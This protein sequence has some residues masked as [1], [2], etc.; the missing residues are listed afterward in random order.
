M[1]TQIPL[2]LAFAA[3]TIHATPTSFAALNSVSGTIQQ[4]EGFHLVGRGFDLQ[5]RGFDIGDILGGSLKDSITSLLNTSITILNAILTSLEAGIPVQN[6][7]VRMLKLMDM[8]KNMDMEEM[9]MP[10]AVAPPGMAE[11]PPTMARVMA[12]QTS[13]GG[14]DENALVPRPGTQPAPNMN[15]GL[16]QSGNGEENALTPS[17]STPAPP[18]GAAAPPTPGT[19]PAAPAARSE[20]PVAACPGMAIIFARGTKEVGNVGLLTGPPFFQALQTYMNGSTS[21][22]IQGL[23]Y[24]ASVSG[25]RQ[26]G[27][28]K[29][30]QKMARLTT[31]TMNACPNTRLVLAGYSQGAQIVRGACA[32]LPSNMTAALSSVVLF[33]DPLNGTAVTGVPAARATTI[34][35]AG[36][37]ICRQGSIVSPAHL[38]YSL[39]AASAAMFVMQRSQ[40]GIVSSDGM[41]AGMENAPLVQNTLNIANSA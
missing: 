29:G 6:D 15:T 26:G 17:G 16:V 34:C 32:A 20:A 27:D 22:A 19:P 7:L 41:M 13:G 18:V 2:V 21:L 39:D 36:D 25:F 23:N 30:I 40:F 28:P 12:R 31:L 10:A 9:A 8:G 38:N 5:E 35:H 14:N 24:E 1:R 37:D 3:T 4:D 11:M 33:G